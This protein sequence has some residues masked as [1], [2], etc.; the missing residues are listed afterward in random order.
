MILNKCNFLLFLLVLINI[1]HFAFG[2]L[3]KLSIRSSGFT[4]GDSWIYIDDNKYMIDGRGITAAAFLPSNSRLL[5]MKTCDTYIPNKKNE[6]NLSIDFLEFIKE[7]GGL[8]NYLLTIVSNDESFNNMNSDL[9]QWISK[10]DI[11]LGFRGSYVL[12]LQSDGLGNFKKI[13]SASNAT[14]DSSVSLNPFIFSF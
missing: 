11:S 14:A 9:L 13:A 6:K 3:V 10:Y 5:Y 8:K 12:I 7:I 2:G 4:G 1:S